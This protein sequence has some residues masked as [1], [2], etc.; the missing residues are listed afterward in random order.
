MEKPNS[1]VAGRLLTAPL[2]SSAV[3]KTLLSDIPPECRRSLSGLIVVLSGEFAKFRPEPGIKEES[4]L[5]WTITCEENFCI[6]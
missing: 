2:A 4:A 5:N 6:A 3:N 1:P